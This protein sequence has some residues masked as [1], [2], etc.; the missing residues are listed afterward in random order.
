MKCALCDK[1]LCERGYC[2]NALCVADG[3]DVWCDC[4]E[5][6]DPLADLCEDCGSDLC[7]CGECHTPACELEGFTC[8]VKI[9]EY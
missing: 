7:I 9:N 2:H 1:E 6:E 4:D 8:E 5:W 3:E